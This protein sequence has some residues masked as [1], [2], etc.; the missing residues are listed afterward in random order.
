MTLMPCTTPAVTNTS[1]HPPPLPHSLVG[2]VKCRAPQQLAI[3]AHQVPYT[4]ILPLCGHR[5]LVQLG[6]SPTTSLSRL[7]EQGK[8]VRLEVLDHN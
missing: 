7:A 3:L 2:V 6:L 5:V 4:D 1:Q 8:Q